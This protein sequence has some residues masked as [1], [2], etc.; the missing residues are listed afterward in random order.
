MSLYHVSLPN[1]FINNELDLRCSIAHQGEYADGAWL[2]ATTGLVV[3]YHAAAIGVLAGLSR[4]RVPLEAPV[5]L[6]A[7]ALL[8]QAPL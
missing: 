5:S 7:A 1:M 4:Y 6:Y 8:A 2:D 3:L